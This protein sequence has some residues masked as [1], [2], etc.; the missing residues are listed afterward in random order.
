VNALAII[1]VAGARSS[2]EW[3]RRY[4]DSGQWEDAVAERDTEHS[5][6]VQAVEGLLVWA[7]LTAAEA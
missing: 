7:R 6:W 5:Y 2:A 1:S 4:A 3:A